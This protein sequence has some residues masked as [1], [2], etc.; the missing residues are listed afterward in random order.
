MFSELA[1]LLGFLFKQRLPFTYDLG[2]LVY[3]T[4]ETT[5][6]NKMSKRP[7]AEPSEH[8]TTHR[9]KV[10]VCGGKN[11]TNRRPKY[12]GVGLSSS[13]LYDVRVMDEAYRVLA[14]VLE[15]LKVSYRTVYG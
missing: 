4:I 13:S 11:W 10:R 14:E 12:I 5:E 7:H 2:A 3:P 1:L 15:R 9:T 6:E 8:K